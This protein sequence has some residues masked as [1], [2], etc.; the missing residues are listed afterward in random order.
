MAEHKPQEQRP[1]TA[2]EDSPSFAAQQPSTPDTSGTPPVKAPARPATARTRAAAPAPTHYLVL[3]GAVGQWPQDSIVTADDLKD[4][5]VDR[6][7][8]LGAIQPTQ[9]PIKD[10]PAD[11]SDDH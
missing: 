11:E 10:V 1:T 3:H 2:P 4:I 8:R 6:L 9:E 7:L 5:D